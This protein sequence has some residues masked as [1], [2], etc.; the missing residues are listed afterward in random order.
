MFFLFVK[1]IDYL[2]G[3]LI[4]I[5]SLSIFPLVAAAGFALVPFPFRR[6]RSGSMA[7]PPLDPCASPYMH[8]PPL[9]IDVDSPVGLDAAYTDKEEHSDVEVTIMVPTQELNGEQAPGSSAPATNELQNLAQVHSKSTPS[10]TIYL[11]P[12]RLEI[13][14]LFIHIYSLLQDYDL[15]LCSKVRL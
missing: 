1:Y 13:I 15:L 6:H 11:F 2:C 7:Q 9:A 5:F 10:C 4:S 14:L 8:P 3:N 12:M